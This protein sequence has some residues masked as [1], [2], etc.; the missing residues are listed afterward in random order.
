[1]A[2]ESY[3]TFYYIEPVDNSNF[4]LNISEDGTT[5]LDAEVEIGEYSMTRLAT[6]VQ[7]ALNSIGANSYTVT[8]NR[9]SRT[10]TI[11]ADA[12]FEIRAAT[13]PQVGNDLWPILGF[14]AVDTA[15]ALSHES[16][17]AAGTEFSPQFYLQ[18]YVMQG[19][20]VGATSGVR[21][22][23]T[24]GLVEIV[25]F[26]RQEFIECTIKYQNSRNQASG[27]IKKSATGYEDFKA[28]LDFGI[29]ASPIE[30]MENINDKNSFVTVLLESLPGDNKGLS[31]KIKE[32]L[33]ELPNFYELGPIVFRII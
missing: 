28:F 26:G 15:A 12:T 1:M 20:S 27:P 2:L 19:Q 24:N 13:G 7:T 4:Y 21:A 29:T 32:Q 3:S 22:T 14:S 5:V 18:D 9:E 10:Y 8:F 11:A 25:S 16:N 31:Y 23:T 33:P 30:F 17:N 6:A